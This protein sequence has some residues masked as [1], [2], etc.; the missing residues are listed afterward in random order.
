M[1][2]I[3]KY[4]PILLLL[5]LLNQLKL[6]TELTELK[7]QR[8]SRQPRDCYDVKKL[9]P[10]LP[11]GVYKIYPVFGETDGFLAYC[12]QNTD[13]GGWTVCLYIYIYIFEHLI[14]N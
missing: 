2:L 8:S 6:I 5:K 7:K 3:A 12:D 4:Y 10:T 9:D 14:N 11:S 13:G 1:V